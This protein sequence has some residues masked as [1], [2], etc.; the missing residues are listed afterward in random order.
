MS[1][2][3][4]EQLAHE[5]GARSAAD[6]VGCV[7]DGR[8]RV[9]GWLGSG[10]MGDVYEVV[11]V[12][13]GRRFAMKALKPELAHDAQMVARFKSEAQAVA[14]LT[15]EHIVSIVDS[16]VMS[17][18]VPYFVM[19]RLEGHDL[20]QLLREQG[21]LLAARASQ[22]ALDVCRGL[23]VAHAAGLVH[24]DLKPENL[25]VSVGDDGRE[26]CR[27]LDFGVA[28][29]LG[30]NTAPGAVIGTTR[31]MAPE[32]VGLDLPLTP[33]TDI[34]A[35]AVI[36]YECLSGSLPFDGDTIE[37]VFFKIMNV[38][39]TDLHELRPELPRGLVSAV[40]AGL[41]KQPAARP[42]DAVAFAELLMPYVGRHTPRR[43]VT[44]LLGT[45]HASPEW[46]DRG[47]ITARTPSSDPPRAPTAPSKL[48]WFAVVALVSGL[49]A[50]L[51]TWLAL[52][53]DASSPDST[54]HAAAPA[55]VEPAVFAPPASADPAA[56]ADPAAPST[57]A[58]A[59]DTGASD[60]E[61]L[62]RPPVRS[63]RVGPPR[64]SSTPSRPQVQPPPAFDPQN[65]YGP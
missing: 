4:I 10:G 21:P 63:S 7:L 48:A 12:A 61:P 24:R 65:P 20:R 18:G 33:Q 37:R 16:G 3:S 42:H 14:R 58:S 60:A 15:S 46:S 44:D 9:S 41:E 39:A 26:I 43:A 32:Q 8:Y 23:E 29:S 30:A 40:H 13:L 51:A 52:R 6:L 22:L 55:R 45:A 27:I 64:G 19:E 47:E 34:Y 50:A 2:A 49:A 57:A 5:R 25:F 28:K 36:L 31:Y 35:L 56:T 53:A 59:P 38:P 17:G 62:P 54:P 11:H 1:P